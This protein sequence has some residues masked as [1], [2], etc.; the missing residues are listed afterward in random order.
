MLVITSGLACFGHGL[1]FY[2]VTAAKKDVPVLV[3]PITDADF[4]VLI[5]GL[6]SGGLAV[7]S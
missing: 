1:G 3:V 4:L 6:V 7:R 5:P 2:S